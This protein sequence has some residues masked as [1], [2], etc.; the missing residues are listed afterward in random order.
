M[1]PEPESHVAIVRARDVEPVG[2]GE[3]PGI[4]VGRP[5]G[6]NDQGPAG[7]L[8][9]LNLDISG[10]EPSRPLHR[11]VIAQELLDRGGDEAGIAL[12]LLEL[13]GMTEQGEQ[14]VADEVHRGLVPGDE[15]QHAHG[16]H[17]ALAQ[18]VSLLLGRDEQ[19]QQVFLGALAPLPDKGAKVIAEGS[20]R[21][22]APLH[23]LAIGE[24]PDGVEAAGDVG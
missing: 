4:A 2:I 8:P 7:D 1:D 17:L 5:D 14:P 22:P 15:Q 6:G 3:M 12:E 18:L 9:A 16:Q 10:G 21:R 19:A 23:D 13:V 20:T 11:A 24:Q